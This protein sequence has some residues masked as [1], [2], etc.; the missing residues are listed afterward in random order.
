MKDN[1][2]K[3]RDGGRYTDHMRAVL[4]ILKARYASL[5][6]WKSDDLESGK[7]EQEEQL[8]Y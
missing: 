4:N 2:I 5:K 8:M 1:N 3:I 7:Q 6:T